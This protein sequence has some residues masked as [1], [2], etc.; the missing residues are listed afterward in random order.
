M[1]RQWV[2]SDEKVAP[3]G[4]R[5]VAFLFESNSGVDVP[6]EIEEMRHRRGVVLPE[7]IVTL[8]PRMFRTRENI[9]NGSV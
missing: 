9:E 6:F 4:K 3:L 8:R 5:G 1:A 7:D 2:L